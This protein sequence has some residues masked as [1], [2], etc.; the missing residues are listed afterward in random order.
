MRQSFF[1]S[2]FNLV[3]L[4]SFLQDF[5]FESSDSRTERG[6]S[7]LGLIHRSLEKLNIGLAFSQVYSSFDWSLE[8]LLTGYVIFSI[9]C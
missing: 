7:R 8:L 4:F 9:D 5:E 3:E 6:L 2:D 1:E